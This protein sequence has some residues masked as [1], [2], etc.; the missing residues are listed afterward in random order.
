MPY[1]IES[2]LQGCSGFA[3]V[4]EGTNEPIPGGCHKT[5]AEAIAHMIAVDAAYEQEGRE[6]KQVYELGETEPKFVLEVEIEEEEGLNARQNALYSA[7]EAIAEEYGMFGKGEDG[8]GA[9]YVANS[10]FQER[11]LICANCTFF[12][13]GRRCEI[14]SGDIAPMGICKLW[15]IEERLIGVGPLATPSEEP[16]EEPMEFEAREQPRDKLG[17]F[18]STNDG[19]DLEDDLFDPASNVGYEDLTDAQADFVENLNDKQYKTI[20]DYTGTGHKD[21]NKSQRGA[22]PPPLEGARLAK[23]ADEADVIFNTINKAPRTPAEV[24]AYRGIEAKAGLS[25]LKV[26]DEFIDYG[27]ASLSADKAVA[28]EFAKEGGSVLSVKIPKGSKALSLG[29]LSEMFGEYE[30]LLQQNTRFRV[31]GKKGNEIQVEAIGQI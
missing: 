19:G 11:G 14:V 31:T 15:V 13:G 10:P 6:L 28:K 30:M 16:E 22:P 20:I 2:N 5:K 24:I 27:F 4:K 25:N 7:Y 21:I 8:D 3:V 26:G 18:G 9:H 12:E 17:R 29:M 1:S 23:A